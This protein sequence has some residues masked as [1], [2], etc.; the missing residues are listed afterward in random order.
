MVL[1]DENLPWRLVKLFKQY[2]IE[3][4][5]LVGSRLESVPDEQI[6]EEVRRSGRVFITKDSDYLQ[7]SLRSSTGRLIHLQTPNMQRRE[8]ISFVES[9]MTSIQSF[10]LGAER[11]LRLKYPS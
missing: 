10:I 5:H 2:D 1:I 8:T 9:Q 11:M 4:E 6:W 3:A 7:L